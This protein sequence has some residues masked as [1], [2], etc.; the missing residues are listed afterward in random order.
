[1]VSVE[2]KCAAACVF[3]VIAATAACSIRPA[4]EVSA[5]P[6]FHVDP[7]SL[8]CPPGEMAVCASIIARKVRSHL[9]YDNTEGIP[10]DAEA[11]V[12][13]LLAPDGQVM[14]AKLIGSSGYPRY[15]DAVVRAVETSTMLPASPDPQQRRFTL[16]FHPGVL[17]QAR[18]SP[19]P[20][21][22]KV[23][24]APKPLALRITRMASG[25]MVDCSLP[26]PTYPAAALAARLQGTV[27]VRLQISMDGKPTSVVVA[28]SSGQS[29]LDDAAID[30]ASRIQCRPIGRD[31][32]FEQPFR[33]SLDE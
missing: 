29:G 26:A 28:M 16:T 9:A 13:V 5:L 14:N 23:A 1:L 6:V 7:P 27:R 4:K 18:T 31:V 22:V 17:P 12:S 15:D 32:A 19:V 33:F 3:L 24:V 2:G 21:T 11:K 20:I 8:V 10:P 30:F 25:I